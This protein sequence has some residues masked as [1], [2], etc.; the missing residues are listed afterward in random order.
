MN[1]IDNDDYLKDNK[2]KIA[3]RNVPRSPWSHQ[4]DLRVN[5][6]IPS[7]SG[8]KIEL[9]F[10]IL[11]VFNL[12]NSEWGWVKLVSDTKLLKFHSVQPT[13]VDVGK[14]RYQWLPFSDPAK[15]SN[16]ASRWQAQM[17]IR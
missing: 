1:Y 4:I 17:G 2:G 11:N 16:L 3:E 9:I 5:Q 15:P 14:P 7:F 10:D 12:L 8:H 13:G 6:E